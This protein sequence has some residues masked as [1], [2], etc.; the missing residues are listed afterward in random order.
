MTDIIIH[1]ARIRPM[2]DAD[3]ALATAKAVAIDEGEI[4]QIGS[5][6]EIM[7]TATG[8]TEVIDAQ[9]A[10]LT[11]GLIDSHMHPVWGAE[12]AVGLDF[13]GVTSLET[14]RQM[15]R[16]AAAK[17]PTD[18]WIRGW[19]LDYKAF[20]DG[21]HGS[22]L[23]E[24]A[25]GRPLFI[26]FYDLHTGLANAV[27]MEIAGV[28]GSEEFSDAG[29]VVIDDDGVPTGEL[30]EMSAYMLLTEAA[31]VDEQSKVLD[32]IASILQESA[33]TGITS[34][35]VMDGQDRTLELLDALEARDG[36]LPIRLHVALWHQ[37]GDGDEL[38]DHRIK[39]LGKTGRH[40]RVSMIKMF[41]DGVID[42]GTAWLHS[43]DS[44]G[45][46]TRSF[47]K[48]TE[49][50]A[51]VAARY[52]RAGF[53]LATH[54]CGDAGVAEAMQVYSVFGTKAANGSRHR[55]EHLETLTDSDVQQLAHTD[56]IASMQPL[57]MQ[58]READYS[59]PW[60]KRLG[61]E[62][63]H[64]SFRT[65][66]LIEAGVHVCLGSDWPVAEQ[67]PRVGM[68]WAR[69]RRTPGDVEAP[70]FEPEQRLTATQALWGYTR[71]AAD[72]LGRP[73]LGRI[74]P[75]ARADL[76]LWSNDPVDVDAD[77]LV[78]LPVQLTIL[79]GL[80]V[81]RASRLQ[82]SYLQGEFQ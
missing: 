63:A 7:R 58:W 37:P 28:D 43:P 24:A 74:Q 52:H 2:D 79:D 31:P 57:H 60:T 13:G 11:P 20:S 22:L 19:N 10:T 44:Q 65:Q 32:T 50:Y 66:D 51:D 21:I 18:A 36:G 70:V 33:S 76:V 55:I 46:G 14:V 68:A 56:T 35:A 53:Q 26:L 27:A 67:D 62:R 82:N 59:D 75:G 81:H 38:V 71:W 15:V 49:R 40:Y 25:G 8:T 48:S 73:D 29:V 42:S 72:A 12:L 41:I 30:R 64:R 16:E 5:S 77:E 69:L 61:P 47:W 80:I 23:D 1:N 4:V 45:D 9:G 34:A 3:A 6:D 54:S 17:L 78:N 39:L